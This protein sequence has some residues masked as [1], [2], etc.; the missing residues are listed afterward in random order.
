MSAQRY[1]DPLAQKR[2]ADG[3]CPECGAPVSR[4]D[5]WGGPG[6]SLTDNGAA[7]RIAQYWADQAGQEQES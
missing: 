4:H 2:M 6:C 3:R 5:G 7:E 1:S